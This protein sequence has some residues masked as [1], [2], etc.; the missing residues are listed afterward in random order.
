MKSGVV[1]RD[2]RIE[3]GITG[4]QKWLTFADYVNEDG[5]DDETRASRLD[6]FWVVSRYKRDVAYQTV[7]ESP[8]RNVISSGVAYP[9]NY[10]SGDMYGD[11]FVTKSVLDPR[12]D[13]NIRQ[14]PDDE[15]TLI[16]IARDY[17]GMGSCSD[18]LSLLYHPVQMAMGRRGETD[19]V[20]TRETPEEYTQLKYQ[21]VEVVKNVNKFESSIKHKSNVFSVVVENSNLAKGEEVDPDDEKQVKIETYKKHLR[22]SITQFV[23]DT[24]QGIVPVHTQLFDVQFT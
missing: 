15:N 2:I 4:S 7:L 6:E 19:V 10:S 17:I 12:Y 14:S 16:G 18:Q 24:C 13:M 22:D 9:N 11:V 5:I 8:V 20:T 3:N 1:L 21:M 23:R